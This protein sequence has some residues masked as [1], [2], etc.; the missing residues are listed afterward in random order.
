MKTDNSTIVGLSTRYNDIRVDKNGNIVANDIVLPCVDISDPT[1]YISTSKGYVAPKL[2]TFDCTTG[3]SRL[4][5]MKE[6]VK[7]MFKR[8]SDYKVYEKTTVVWFNDGTKTSATCNEYDNFDVENGIIACVLKR[9]FND[10]YKRDVKAIIKKKA[11]EEKRQKQAQKEL[12]EYKRKAEK[13]E[14]RNRENKLRMKAR[15]EARLAAAIEEEK[16]KL[17]GKKVLNESNK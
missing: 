15:Y 2:R 13:L 10:E 4:T 9:M 11:D 6:G 5:Y 12:D 1:V 8:I 7:N 16:K 3:I 14:K 17:K